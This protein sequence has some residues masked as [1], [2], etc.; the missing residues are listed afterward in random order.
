MPFIYFLEVGYSFSWLRK[1]KGKKSIEAGG[2]RRRDGSG[3]GAFDF[4]VLPTWLI[5]PQR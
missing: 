1:G 3:K 2:G 4:Y 5:G